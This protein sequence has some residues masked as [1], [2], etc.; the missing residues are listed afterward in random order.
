[1]NER[2]IQRLQEQIKERLAEILQR[3]LAD[4]K[5]GMVTISRV[6]LD[7]EF[8]VC[9]AYWSVIATSGKG[10]ERARAD[11]DAVLQRARGFCQRE[12][13]RSLNTRTI[14]RLEFVYD[15]GVAGAVRLNQL[16]KDLVKKPDG[17]PAESPAPP[18]SGNPP[19]P[20]A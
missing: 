19:P 3:D 7:T 12:V 5:L 16:L 1:M 18:D 2:R 10:E 4:P 8:T 14:P 20:T 17:A 15:G 6:E 9:K 11:S 13:G